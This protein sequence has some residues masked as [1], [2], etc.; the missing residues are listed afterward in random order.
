MPET[1]D[2]CAQDMGV[3]ERG[4]HTRGVC[5]RGML[6]LWYTTTIEEVGKATTM[7]AGYGITIGVCCLCCVDFSWGGKSHQDA[8]KGGIRVKRIVLGFPLESQ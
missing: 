3:H 7:L 6:C 5:A 2:A 1:G 4:M 8:E